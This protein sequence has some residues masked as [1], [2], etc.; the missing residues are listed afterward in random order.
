[1]TQAQLFIVTLDLDI[2]REIARALTPPK[3]LQEA[4]ELAV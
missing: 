4:G 3:T 2:Q 1:M